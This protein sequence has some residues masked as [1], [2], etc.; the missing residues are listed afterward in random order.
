[1]AVRER[2]GAT[3]V[4]LERNGVLQPNPPPDLELHAGDVLLVYGTGEQ[5][6]CV[7]ELL[8]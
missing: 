5:L 4:A 1:M 2:T 7:R 3:V 6:S 8:A